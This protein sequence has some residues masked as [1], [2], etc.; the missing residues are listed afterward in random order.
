M[1]H[2]YATI[3]ILVP[4]ESEPVNC[5]KR[6]VPW[7]LRNLYSDPDQQPKHSKW[8]D[9]MVRIPAKLERR[10][11]YWLNVSMGPNDVYGAGVF[12]R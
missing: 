2:S 4:E 3:G 1:I 8:Y 7:T 10:M 9:T 12:L 5:Q 11:K 6:R